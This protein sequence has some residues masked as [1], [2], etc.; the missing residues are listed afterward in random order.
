[1]SP[2][3]ARLTCKRELT[4]SWLAIDI[5]SPLI[6]KILSPGYIRPL[7]SATSFD[8]YSNSNTNIKHS[9]NYI[10]YHFF[11]NH[12]SMSPVKQRT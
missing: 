8:N 3:I 5:S 12:T 6:D 11:N 10:T 9:N 2:Y 1:M 7:L 4:K